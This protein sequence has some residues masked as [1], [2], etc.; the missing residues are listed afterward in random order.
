MNYHPDDF[1]ALSLA[2]EEEGGRC[3]AEPCV[4]EEFRLKQPAVGRKVWKRFRTANC[5]TSAKMSLP[6]DPSLYIR[7][8]D[9]EDDGVTLVEHPGEK[10]S[11]R[12]VIVCAVDDAVGLMPRFAGVVS[13]RS[14][15]LP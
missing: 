14:Y 10:L 4:G 3:L 13:D 6:Y 5:G 2:V 9:D 11:K 7:L 15:Q 1:V 8:M 12:E